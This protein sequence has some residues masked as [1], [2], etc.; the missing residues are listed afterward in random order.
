MI[1]DA[2]IEHI[3]QLIW[4]LVATWISNVLYSLDSSL[5]TLSKMHKNIFGVVSFNREIQL[6]LENRTG[7]N[8]WKNLV[9]STKCLYNGVWKKNSI[10]SFVER[11][12]LYRTMYKRKKFER[13]KKMKIIKH[14][15]L[16]FLAVL[17]NVHFTI[18]SKYVR[19]GWNF[20]FRGYEWCSFFCNQKMQGS[21]FFRVWLYRKMLDI[22]MDRLLIFNIYRMYQVEQ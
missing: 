2:V 6:L 1:I 16:S 7:K 4:R 22:L 18:F 10:C 15:F 19:K 12:S 17:L 21:N 20:G 8:R 5:F 11:I 3:V 9:L 13:V 14:W